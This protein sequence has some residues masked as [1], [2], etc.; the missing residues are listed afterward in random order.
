VRRCRRNQR[1]STAPLDRVTKHPGGHLG[2][3][4]TILLNRL[5]ANGG[6]CCSLANGFAEALS[7]L[8]GRAAEF[9]QVVVEAATL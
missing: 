3:S 5:L 2:A 9:D 6:P 4:K 7:T 8:K 1:T